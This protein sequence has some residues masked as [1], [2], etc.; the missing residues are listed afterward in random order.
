[1]ESDISKILSNV[2]DLLGQGL[3]K[4]E[5]LDAVNI[6]ELSQEHAKRVLSRVDDAVVSGQL[7]K[8][9][10]AGY[11][12]K[13]VFGMVIF[14]LG[15]FISVGTY[16]LGYSKYMLWY[17]AIIAGAWLAKEGYKEMKIEEQKIEIRQR[18]IVKNNKFK[19]F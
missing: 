4:D 12:V 11:N 14:V 6:N 18:K 9:T 16:M 5:I 15:V 1:M 19:R 13:F 10:K 2:D 8:Q 17:G 7:R 3:S